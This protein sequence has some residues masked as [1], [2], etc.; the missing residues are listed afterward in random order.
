MKMPFK[1]HN[2]P[3]LF[4]NILYYKFNIPHST[5]LIYMH[6]NIDFSYYFL[7]NGSPYLNAEV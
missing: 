7:V 1:L 4:I 3:S 5:D 6:I 2:E